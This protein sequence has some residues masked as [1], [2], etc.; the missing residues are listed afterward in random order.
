MSSTAMTACTMR[1][2][3]NSM[4]GEDYRSIRGEVEAVEVGVAKAVAKKLRGSGSIN[5]NAPG[6]NATRWMVVSAE[7]W[8]SCLPVYTTMAI[9]KMTREIV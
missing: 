6:W 3:P 7:R 5:N 2:S 4:A 1:V 8:L 9:G